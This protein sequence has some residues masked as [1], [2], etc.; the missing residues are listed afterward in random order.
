MAKASM[1]MIKD[2]LKWNLE[3][4]QKLTFIGQIAEGTLAG[5]AVKDEAAGEAPSK[6]LKTGKRRA[7]G[8]NRKVKLWAQCKKADPQKVESLNYSK[9]K[10]MELERMLAKARKAK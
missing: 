1:D 5:P 8:T 6:R 9:V 4:E 3:A 10:I 7:T 2:V